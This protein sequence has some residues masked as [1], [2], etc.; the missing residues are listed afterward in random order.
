M[1]TSLCYV[2]R[3][4][5][6]FTTLPLEEQWGDNWDEEPYET[7]SSYPYNEK[8]ALGNDTISQYAMIIPERLVRK[9]T[10]VCPCDEWKQSPYTVEEINEGYEPWIKLFFDKDIKDPFLI[11][12]NAGA[13]IEE[14][15]EVLTEVGINLIEVKRE[16]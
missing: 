10:I 15:S 13:T 16:D 8:D 14:V 4:K 3:N 11:E 2:D 7:K 12:L 1:K 5:L 6:F 9:V